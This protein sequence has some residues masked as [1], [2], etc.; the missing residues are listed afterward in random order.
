MKKSLNKVYLMGFLGAD[1]EMQFSAKN[2]MYTRLSLATH[3]SYLNAEEQWETKTDWHSVFVWGK[4]AE[5]CCHELQKG[6]LIFVEG[7]LTYWKV[8]EQKEY[9][10][11]IHAEDVK[12]L[13][14]STRALMAASVPPEV[15]DLDNSTGPRN[16][17]AVAHPA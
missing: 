4:L 1:P 5:R 12:F 10:N 17:N 6:A 13:A 11:A 8:A 16:H 3:R 15:A 14:P 2:N 7:E 9:K